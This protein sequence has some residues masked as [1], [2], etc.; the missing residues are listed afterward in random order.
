MVHEHFKATISNTQLYADVECHD[1]KTN[2][3]DNTMPIPEPLFKSPE[4]S[5]SVQFPQHNLQSHLVS[6]SSSRPS[7]SHISND[8]YPCT[9]APKPY[10]LLFDELESVIK[11]AGN[12][13][14]A[15]SNC[16]TPITTHFDKS[17]L[18][19]MSH[20]HQHCQ[21][22]TDTPQKDTES[23]S[24]VNEELNQIEFAP[25]VKAIA[26]PQE[27][28]RI[29]TNDIAMIQAEEP[30]VVDTKGELN[31]TVAAASTPIN[32]DLP[33]NK[34]CKLSSQ[35]ESQRIIAQRIC[36]SPIS[37]YTNKVQ[38]DYKQRTLPF[39]Q[40]QVQPI[41]DSSVTAS[42]LPDYE[43]QM[44]ENKE[45]L[46][47]D[48]V[49]RCSNYNISSTKIAPTL[50]HNMIPRNVTISNS[51]HDNLITNDTNNMV[52]S[53]ATSLINELCF[54]ANSQ[55]LNIVDQNPKENDEM[56]DI[57]TTAPQASMVA[58]LPHSQI[59]PS[60][61]LITSRNNNITNSSTSSVC[62]KFFV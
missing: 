42:K 34:L 35:T 26:V 11:F 58:I 60:N 37:N 48:S 51:M 30:I 20:H 3:Y 31:V 14:N 9:S 56:K 54:D 25:I 38:H 10:Q 12:H 15:A 49:D 29:R 28:E 13:P 33:N 47:S 7:T 16:V 23:T 19:Q 24:D 27:H 17:N 18:N 5:S 22:P 50:S 44:M 45:L 4:A 21:L 43:I 39:I 62:N 1:G 32:H 52:A 57:Q 36:L 53:N 6:N 8:F 59:A 55:Q 41:V 2:L 46:Q 40:E 61:P